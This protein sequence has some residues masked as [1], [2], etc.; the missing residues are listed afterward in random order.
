[1]SDE[2][3]LSEI[4]RYIDVSNH[5]HKKLFLD[6]VK[7]DQSN[8]NGKD[9]AVGLWI[10]FDNTKSPPQKSNLPLMAKYELKMT[11]ERLRNIHKYSSINLSMIPVRMI[12]FKTEK[13]GT[14]D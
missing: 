9:Y 13:N 12:K 10:L 2:V 5:V 1:L 3:F 6:H 14:S 8:V 4:R 11:Y 7:E